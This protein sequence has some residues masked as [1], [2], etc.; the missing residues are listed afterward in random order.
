MSSST[1][2]SLSLPTLLAETSAYDIFFILRANCLLTSARNPID[3]VS[4]S[5]EGPLESGAVGIFQAE[6]DFA[7][8]SEERCR[9]VET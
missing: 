6:G 5:R 2:V 9:V 4:F 7:L 8:V 1:S 3:Q